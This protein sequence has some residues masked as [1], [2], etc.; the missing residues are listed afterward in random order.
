MIASTKS[1]PLHGYQDE[2]LSGCTMCALGVLF[3][4]KLF[5]FR[6]LA[7]TIADVVE[8][9]SPDSTGAYD[10]DT[11]DS[12]RVQREDTLDSDTV[13][14]LSY[15]KGSANSAVVLRDDQAFKHLDTLCRAFND[16]KMYFYGISDGEVFRILLELY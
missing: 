9:R 3:A 8:F 1:T 4:D 11:L 10:F 16:F 12:R 2:H 7:D 15:G 14:N 6:F 13:G 5:D